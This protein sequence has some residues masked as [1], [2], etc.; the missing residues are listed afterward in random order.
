MG[1]TH[2]NKVTIRVY[3]N[4]LRNSKNDDT[5]TFNLV[6]VIIIETMDRYKVLKQCIDTIYWNNVLIECIETIGYYDHCLTVKNKK[7]TII[8]SWILL[9]SY[10]IYPLC[11]KVYLFARLNKYRSNFC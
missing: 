8:G 4:V 6:S 10:T 9:Q 3:K 7:V 1:L 11:V 2:L 5:F